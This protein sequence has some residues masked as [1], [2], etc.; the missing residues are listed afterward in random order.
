MAGLAAAG[1]AAAALFGFW[2]RATP[3]T[4]V[5]SRESAYGQIKI[6]DTEKHRY[7][8]ING[9]AQS[10][11]ELPSLEGVSPVATGLE[12][13]A[14][15]RPAPRALVIG[16]GAGLLSG[17]LE[18]HHG[19]IV[20]SVELD[21][22]V[23]ESAEKQF[24]YRPK[25][26]IFKED[27]RAFLQRTD[28]RYGLVFV[29]AFGAET[30]P[31]QLFTLESFRRMREVLEPGGVLAINLG[32]G[33]LAGA[34]AAWP[35][36]YKTLKAVFPEV[37]AYRVGDED[38]GIGNALVFCSDAPLDR[39]Q[40]KR[41]RPAIRKAVEEMLGAELL[42]SADRLDAATLLTDD[43]WSSSSRAPR[44][45]GAASCRKRFRRCFSTRCCARK[46]SSSASGSNPSRA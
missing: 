23:I 26:S 2:P 19:T 22:A 38:A 40:A 28:A 35:S 1:A 45:A 29:D 27:G 41:A 42:P 39:A 11:A 12:W 24:G 6:L 44:C 20:D 37:R 13:A 33:E 31:Y 10:M 18:R 25:G 4:N 17:A 8:L 21:P 9:T 30:P 5:I 36:A 34:G 46:S 7:L 15:A 14:V 43:R 16:L 3:E 32:V